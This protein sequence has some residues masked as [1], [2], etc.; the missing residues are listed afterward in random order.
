[1]DRTGEISY[2]NFGTRMVIVKYNGT[3]DIIVEF[4]DE[5]KHRVTTVYS[6]FKNGGSSPSIPK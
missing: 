2:N 4:Q 5:Y 1:M 3:M 6:S